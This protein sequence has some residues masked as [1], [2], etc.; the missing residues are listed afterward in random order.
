MGM[1]DPRETLLQMRRAG[2]RQQIERLVLMIS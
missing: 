1:R 2:M